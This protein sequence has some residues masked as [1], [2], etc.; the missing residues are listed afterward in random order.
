MTF[1]ALLLA[2]GESRRMGADKA[3]LIVGGEPLW[4]RQLSLLRE[5]HPE[6]LWVSARNRPRWCPPDVEVVLD[7]PPSYGPLSGLS[8][9]LRQLRT[10]HLIALAVDLPRM[11]SAH[12][13]HL[14]SLASP[15]CGVI[16]RNEG[17]FEPLCAIYP[18]EAIGL[19]DT[20]DGNSS[21]QPCVQAL[22]HNGLA[23]PYD[24]TGFERL[25]YHNANFPVDL[26]KTSS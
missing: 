16:P 3:T 14:Q 9:A 4:S 26:D 11:T 2:G 7:I 5:L 8:A 6:A 12:L 17:W 1:T 10:T 22:V 13:R 18:R 19:L 24:P 15:G 21:M 23:R 25:L 20:S